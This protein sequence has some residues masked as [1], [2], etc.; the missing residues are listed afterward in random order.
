MVKKKLPVKKFSI[1][2]FAKKPIKHKLVKSSNESECKVKKINPGKPS[3]GKSDCPN[4]NIKSA[5][6]DDYKKTIVTHKKE[7]GG[8]PPSIHETTRQP[9][10]SSTSTR[11]D[12]HQKIESST[13]ANK[14]TTKEE[15]D[16][17]KFKAFQEIQKIKVINLSLIQNIRNIKY[18][19]NAEGA[20]SR[21]AQ[22][23]QDMP[24]DVVLHPDENNLDANLKKIKT[25][26]PSSIDYKYTSTHYPKKYKNKKF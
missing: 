22:T 15:E 12:I 17:E 5:G 13:S 26:A 21:T 9:I 8:I 14:T 16:P 6:N 18:I 1:A 2:A 3:N 24:T 10:E 7:E 19:E 20:E 4:N 23:N 11:E 25:C